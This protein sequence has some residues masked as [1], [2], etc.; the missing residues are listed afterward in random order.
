MLKVGDK[1]IIVDAPG[2]VIIFPEMK[3]YVGKLAT[4]D[5]I[6]RTGFCTRETGFFIWCFENAIPAN[7]YP[8]KEVDYDD[9]TWE[10][11]PF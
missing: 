4:V 7:I 8:K 11:V 1:V 2:G 9:D 3:Q 6:E 10:I 5:H